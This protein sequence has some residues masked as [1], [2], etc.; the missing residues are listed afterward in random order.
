MFPWPIP[1]FLLFLTI[2]NSVSQDIRAIVN[3][4]LQ[5]GVFPTS[6]KT[7]LVKPLSKK[8]NLDPPISKLEELFFK[9]LSVI[10]NS[11]T[12]LEMFQSGKSSEQHQNKSGHQ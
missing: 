2:F 8:G 6:L 4:S 10:L 7:A 3:H 1:T 11:N 5:L 12:K 9:H